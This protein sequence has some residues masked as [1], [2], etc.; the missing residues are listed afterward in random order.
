MKNQFLI[1]LMLT[2]SISTSA[3]DVFFSNRNDSLI[4]KDTGAVSKLMPP[5]EIRAVRAGAEYPFTQNMILKKTIEKNNLGQDIPFILNQIPGAVIN[6]DAGNGIGY[7]GIR[8][9]G[10]DPTRIN[11]TLNGI[12]Y[13]DAESQ[14]VFLVNLPDFLSSTNSIQVQRGVG[15]SSN[16]TGAFGATV[17]LLTNE[18]EPEA[19]GTISNSFGSYN[20]RKNTLKAGTG[21]INKRYTVDIRLSSIYSDGYID[22]ASSDLKSFYISTAS[23]KENSSLRLNVFSGKEKQQE[24]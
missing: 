2:I 13:N 14:G 16:G 12:A 18:I 24:I 15:T 19:Y 5:I 1:M 9:R 10:T 4:K 6:S 17:N 8:I 11:F 20:T 7:T 21:L 23:I 3:Q 22:R